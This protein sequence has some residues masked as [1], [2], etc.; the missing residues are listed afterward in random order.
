MDM[1]LTT[2]YTSVRESVCVCVYL[3]A[4]HPGR[5]HKP[6][7]VSVHHGE[8]T[9]GPGC[10]SPGV[11][12]GMLFLTRLLWILKHDLKHL[13]EVLT[14]MMGRGALRNTK[15]RQG[16]GDFMFFVLFL[17]NFAVKYQLKSMWLIICDPSFIKTSAE[18]YKSN[19]TDLHVNV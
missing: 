17:G 3:Q 19:I 16:Q 15:Q 9:N 11:L 6:H 2:I 4:G 7:V 10:D 14:K 18:I 5:Q 12:E 8:D 1:S 13:G